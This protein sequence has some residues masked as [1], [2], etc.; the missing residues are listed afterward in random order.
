MI[1]TFP[2][3]QGEFDARKSLTVTVQPYDQKPIVLKEAER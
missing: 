3:D 2:V 1:V